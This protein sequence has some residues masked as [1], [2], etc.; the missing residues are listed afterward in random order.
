[1]DITSTNITDIAPYEGPNAISGI[2]FRPVRAALG[3]TAWGMNAIEI[4]AGVGAY[5]QHD[6]AEDR[7]EEVYLVL[8]GSATLHVGDRELTVVRGDF[9]HVPAEATRRFT[10]DDTR[11]TLLAIGGVPGEAFVP[12]M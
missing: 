8:D 1:M 4:D 6:H 12:R 7:Q 3:V 10:T 5:P 2:R 9:V 11:V